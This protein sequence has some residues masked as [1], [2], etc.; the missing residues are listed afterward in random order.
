MIINEYKINS[1]FSGALIKIN[2]NHGKIK[3]IG[4]DR[5]YF[6]LEGKGKFIINK[7]ENKVG[8]KD[9]IFLPKN[10][11]YNVTGKIKLFLICSP[12][13]NRKDDIVL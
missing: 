10:T 6:I 9:L 3:C 1:K 7:K 5:I 12:K 8:P 2:G 13:F 11:A 4:E